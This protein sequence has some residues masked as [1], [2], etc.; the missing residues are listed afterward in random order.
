[1]HADDI[2]DVISG[3]DLFADGV[4]DE[5]HGA[6][7]CE[8]QGYNVTALQSYNVHTL[9]REEVNSKLEIRN[10]KQMSWHRNHVAAVRPAC[11]RAGASRPADFSCP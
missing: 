1:M 10:P 11:R 9:K 3:A 8:L 6:A 4:G 7:G 2:H 5:G